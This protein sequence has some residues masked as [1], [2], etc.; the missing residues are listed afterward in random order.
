MIHDSQNECKNLVF[1]DDATCKICNKNL[2]FQSGILELF[3]RQ[4]R[5]SIDH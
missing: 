2:E 1:E 4:N 3:K 5:L